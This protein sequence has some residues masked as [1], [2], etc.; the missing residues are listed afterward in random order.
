LSAATERIELRRSVAMAAAE[1]EAAQGNPEKARQL[2]TDLRATLAKTGMTLGELECRTA[3]LRLD[4]AEKRPTVEA[5]A[6]ALAKDAK[7]RHAGLVLRRA[8]VR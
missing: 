8:S 3:L 4:R 1:V 7:A 2:L 5:D 6:T